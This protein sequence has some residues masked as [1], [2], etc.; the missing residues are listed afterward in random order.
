MSFIISRYWAA[1][2]ALL[3]LTLGFGGCTTKPQDAVAK[4]S[5][6]AQGLPEALLSITGTSPSDVWAVGADNGTGP[7]VMH[8]DGD[9]WARLSTRTSGHLWTAHA[10]SSNDVFVGGASS[11]ILRWDGADFS[12]MA[13]PGLGRDSVYSIWASSPTSAYAVGGFGGRAGF[14]WRWDGRA[15]ARVPLPTGLPLREV[16]QNGL[17]DWPS[18][19]SVWGDTA[20]R[21]WVVGANGAILRADD[22]EHFVVVPSGTH[23]TLFTITG[24]GERVA[25]VGGDSAS[26]ALDGEGMSPISDRSPSLLLPIQGVS[27][28]PRA[29]YAS[30][31][32]GLMLE[33]QGN[34]WVKVSHGLSFAAQSLHATWIDSAGGVWAVG[35]DV[36]DRS[37]GN[38]A[39]IHLGSK[40]APFPESADAGAAAT[41]VACPENAIDPA[42]TRASIARRWDEQILDA[43]RRDTPRPGVHARN[44][45]HLSAAMWDAWAAYDSTARGAFVNERLTSK[46][47]ATAREEAISYAAY[48]VLAYRYDAARAVGAAVSQACFRALMDRL[49]YDADDMRTTGS[50]PRALGNRIGAAVLAMSADDGANESNNYA[51]TTG[52]H[53]VNVPLVVDEPGVTCKD[54]SFWQKL[55][56]AEPAT[57]NGISVPAG[58]QGYIGAQWGEVRPFALSERLSNGLFFD[59]VKAPTATQ[60]EMVDWI[61][62]MIE[63]QAALSDDPKHSIDISPGAYGNNPLASNAGTGT[64]ANPATGKAYA[65]NVVPLGDFARVLAEFWADGPKSETPPGHWNV[66]ANYISDSPLGRRCL[67]GD[68]GCT[69]GKLPETDRLEWDL[70]IYL[71]LNGALHDAAIVA[72]GTKRAFSGPRPI[73]LVRWLSQQ[74]LLPTRPGLIEPITAESSARG[75]RHER[76][77]PFVGELAVLGW[78]G[79]PGDRANDTT[80]IQWMRAAEW[81]PYQRRSFVTPAF[82]G[83]ISGHSTFSRS[84][85]EVFTELTGSQYFPGGLGEFV[86]RANEYLVF[87]NGPSVEVRLQ[88]ASFYDASDQ[89]GQSRLY[90]GIHI[91]PDDVDGRRLGDRVGRLA[92]VKARTLFDGTAGP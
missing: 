80:P 8:Y 21:I 59:G 86:A 19:L 79:E 3:C 62:E 31:R 52:W 24:D 39:M 46:G 65:P 73:T 53:S 84:A 92:V 7:I 90:G 28:T 35:G 89:A 63:K 20:G 67:F 64:A 16:G 87:E 74:H 37:L 48:R 77:A 9:A 44:L 6:V 91:R 29:A 75:E 72:W 32:L 14:I 10:V 11:T 42:P 56:L 55:N 57:Q 1:C 68:A 5:L 13:T 43:I 83:Y 76:L 22:G 36:L 17:S 70:K 69:S 25:I 78:P 85:A 58:E 66:L 4:W 33:R 38:G 40:V 45:Y 18:F 12:R 88:W 50:S 49:G 41:P 61:V 34:A 23:A 30:G 71:A 26:V 15:W 81:V 27:I 51:D 2:I 60:P 82:P 54:A 47:V